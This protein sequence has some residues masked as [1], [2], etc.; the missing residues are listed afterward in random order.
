MTG[1]PPLTRRGFLGVAGAGLVASAALPAPRRAAPPV[2]RRG[3]NLWPW[4]SLTREYPA[5]RTDYAWP[6]FQE[7]RPVPT[8]SDLRR[9]AA[10]GFDFVRLPVDPGP[11]LFFE[12]ARRQALVSNLE[13][14]VETALAAGLSVVVNLQANGATHFYNPER[15]FGAPEAPLLEGYLRLAG[16]VAGMLARLGD[17][18]LAIEPVN[19]PPGACGAPAW[20]LLQARLVGACREAAPDLAYVA[21]GACGSMVPG[22]EALDPAPDLLAGPTLFTFHFYEPYLFTHQGAPWMREPVYRALNEVPWPADQGDLETVLAAVRRRMAADPAL[23]SERREAAYAETVRVMTEYFA[24]RPARWFVDGYMARVAAWG[25]RHGLPPSR[26]L[27]G[28]FG[29][30]GSDARYVAAGRADR[31]RYL[32]DVRK[33]AEASGFG[34]ALW[35][36]FD[37]MGVM[38]D[39]S[40]ALDPPLLAALGLRDLD[41]PPR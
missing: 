25:A 16:T 27:L 3:V 29:A 28:E 15:M 12:G 38:D 37:G 20:S 11:F 6:P 24:A 22:L 14:A 1:A 21:T 5:P 8:G 18:R 2:L 34:W 36:L 9:L 13:G 33:S 19:E 40:H 30:L 4:F 39:R 17:P 26:I 35:N 31:L 32:R 7:G 10:A 41:P 23:T